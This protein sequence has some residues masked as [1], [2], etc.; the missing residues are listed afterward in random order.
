MLID[1]KTGKLLTKHG[2]EKMTSD[3]M[4][5]DFPWTPLPVSQILENIDLVPGGQ[6]DAIEPVKFSN[7]N[8]LV[9]GFYFSAH[10]VRKKNS[11]KHVVFNYLTV[12]VPSLSMLHSTVKTNLY[13]PK[14]QKRWV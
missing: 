4:G 11:G 9:I 3:P 12:S 5:L 7:L 14:E 13:D 2:I 1:G 6:A 8:G 10:W